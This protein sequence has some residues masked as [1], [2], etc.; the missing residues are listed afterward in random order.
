M[1]AYANVR[2][3][4]E[5]RD[6][7]QQQAVRGM[8]HLINNC[9][10]ANSEL[11]GCNLRRWC[12]GILDDDAVIIPTVSWSVALQ[13]DDVPDA[14]KLLRSGLLLCRALS[15][16]GRHGRSVASHPGIW[17]WPIRRQKSNRADISQLLLQLVLLFRCSGLPDLMDIANLRK[18]AHQHPMAVQIFHHQHGRGLGRLSARCAVLPLSEDQGPTVD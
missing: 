10:Y 8:G 9:A 18:G 15:P 5:N 14:Y 6:N 12:V 1:N 3:L 2:E 7:V 4:W 16:D 13:E 11:R 17:S